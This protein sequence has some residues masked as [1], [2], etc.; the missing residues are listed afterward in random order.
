M[1]YA[2][3]IFQC[4]FLSVKPYKNFLCAMNNLFTV[5]LFDCQVLCDI[6][7]SGGLPGKRIEQQQPSLYFANDDLEYQ[8]CLKCMKR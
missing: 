2:Y 5:R 7:G 6:L 8:V 4:S 3:L 1:F